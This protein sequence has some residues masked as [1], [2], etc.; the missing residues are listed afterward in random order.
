[1]STMPAEAIRS[2]LHLWAFGEGAEVCDRCGDIIWPEIELVRCDFCVGKHGVPDPKLVQKAA[3]RGKDRIRA[4]EREMRED[5][6]PHEMTKIQAGRILQT[7]L[8]DPMTQVI[9]RCRKVV[10]TYRAW[11]SHLRSR[12]PRLYEQFR[13]DGTLEED[14][15]IFQGRTRR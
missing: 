14:R 13:M 9:C 15:L 10:T 3:E 11:V 4:Y 6:Y 8:D 7:R 12:H 5:S 1:M 2:L